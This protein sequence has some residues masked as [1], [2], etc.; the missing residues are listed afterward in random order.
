[1]LTD[2]PPPAQKPPL[3]FEQERNLQITSLFLIHGSKQWKHRS[4]IS[5]WMTQPD[6]SFT[7]QFALWTSKV[8]VE[9]VNMILTLACSSA[10]KSI[11]HKGF[12]ANCCRKQKHWLPEFFF[13]LS[14][15]MDRG[16]NDNNKYIRCSEALK[17]VNRFLSAAP[18]CNNNNMT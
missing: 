1:M 17:T 11:Y 7:Q 9:R 8:S 15:S 3:D 16:E 4:V 10:D 12:A 13:F 2:T 14:F 6:Q 18:T 5:I